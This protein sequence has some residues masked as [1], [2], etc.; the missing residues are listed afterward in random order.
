MIWK[1][2]TKVTFKQKLEE[3]EEA[4]HADFWA[5]RVPGKG[6]HL[7]KSLKRELAWQI[8][9]TERRPECRQGGSQWK[10]KTGS[11]GRRWSCIEQ[12][13]SIGRLRFYFFNKMKTIIGFKQRTYIIWLKLLQDH[14][15]CHRKSRQLE[16]NN[17]NWES[18]HIAGCY[19][20]VNPAEYPDL[21]DLK[22]E[23]EAEVKDDSQGFG[24]VIRRMASPLIL[25]GQDEEL[26]RLRSLS[27]LQVK[28]QVGRR[29]DVNRVQRGGL[30]CR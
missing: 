1:V 8:L 28:L 17:G 24:L 26:G 18:S 21:L 7:Y 27:G 19:V 2:S 29:I 23:R 30:S 6:N 15:G 12:H 16:N 22:S 14:P 11:I 13:W 3:K 9:G 25:A 10:L 20:A 4:S 5:E